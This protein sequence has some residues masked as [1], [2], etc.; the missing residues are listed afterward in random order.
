VLEMQKG[1]FQN[2]SEVDRAIFSVL[3]G[4]FSFWLVSA[5]E[6][7]IKSLSVTVEV[8]KDAQPTKLDRILEAKAASS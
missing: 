5:V 8:A 3:G 7:I 1:S 2:Q 6:T 4:M